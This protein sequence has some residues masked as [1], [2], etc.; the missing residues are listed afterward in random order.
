MALRTTL[1]GQ[2][3]G[4]ALKLNVPQLQEALRDQLGFRGELPEFE[5]SPTIQLTFDV[6]QD[7]PSS[8]DSQLVAIE[9]RLANIYLILAAIS[10]SLGGYGRIT[11]TNTLKGQ[12]AQLWNVDD[13]NDIISWKVKEEEEETANDEET[14]RS[15]P[16]GSPGPSTRPKGGRKARPRRND[17][18]GD[19]S[20]D[21]A[22]G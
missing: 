19:D 2:L 10:T 20:R 4:P 12:L 15:G 3:G 9:E 5:I 14:P 11:N 16:E 22:G 1:P 21:N 6:V 13:D 8:D 7:D 18:P 17:S